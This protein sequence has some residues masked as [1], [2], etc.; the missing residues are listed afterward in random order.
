MRI[1][2]VIQESNIRLLRYLKN[3]PLN[4]DFEEEESFHDLWRAFVSDYLNPAEQGR[5]SRYL[6][7]PIAEKSFF[8]YRV[9]PSSWQRRFAEFMEEH[10]YDREMLYHNPHHAPAW[11]QLSLDHNSCRARLGSSI[12][13]HAEH[14]AQEGFT[15]GVE[16]L[17]QLHLTRLGDVW[18]MWSAGLP[19]TPATTSPIKSA[20]PISKFMSWLCR[21]RRDVPE[22]GC[23]GLARR[24]SRGSGDLLWSLY[25]AL[26]Y[27]AAAACRRN[28]AGRAARL[29]AGSTPIAQPP[30]RIGRS[31]PIRMSAIIR[32]CRALLLSLR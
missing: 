28:L 16:K 24:R 10:G 25:Q 29:G 9:L 31:Q 19:R 26:S 27:S 6:G 32:K 3:K 5:L 20:R 11:M 17:D 21:E 30:C 2:E 18:G 12:Q 14:I 23:S 8:D 1:H 15:R 7:K 4:P 22:R 13:R